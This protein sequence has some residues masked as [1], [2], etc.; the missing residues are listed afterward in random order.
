MMEKRGIVGDERM[1]QRGRQNVGARSLLPNTVHKA[2]N[3]C[4]GMWAF[5]LASCYPLP[6]ILLIN[7]LSSLAVTYKRLGSIGMFLSSRLRRRGTV[8]LACYL[9]S[10]KLRVGAT[11]EQVERGEA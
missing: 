6:D 2:P 5:A 9:R 8:T 3:R 10:S 7:S 1:M 11:V 4:P